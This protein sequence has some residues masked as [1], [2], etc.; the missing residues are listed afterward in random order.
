MKLS[1]LSGVALASL[2]IAAATASAVS[3]LRVD[4]IPAPS[5]DELQQLLT[6]EDRARAV[7]ICGFG[8]YAE[9]SNVDAL[10][11]YWDT[12][13]RRPLVSLVCLDQ[14]RRVWVAAPKPPAQPGSSS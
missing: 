9:R 2:V 13:Q 1:T 3:H 12:Q 6:A 5:R 10:Y 4:P 7:E 8:T 14:R 11:V